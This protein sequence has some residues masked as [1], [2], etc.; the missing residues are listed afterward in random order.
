M[1]HSRSSIW[2]ARV[3]LLGVCAVS[4]V[5]AQ[6]F[7]PPFEAACVV[8]DN[9]TRFE[10]VLDYDGDGRMDAVS[11]LFPSTTTLRVRG[12]RNDGAGQLVPDWGI[13]YPGVNPITLAGPKA[14]LG[15]RRLQRRRPRRLRA[16]SELLPRLLDLGRS[17]RRAVGRLGDA[18]AGVHQRDPDGRLRRR[19]A[20]RRRAPRRTGFGRSDHSPRVQDAAGG[21]A[22][23]DLVDDVHGRRHS[24]QIFRVE[25]NGDG[26]P[27]VGVI[28]SGGL[29]PS[30]AIAEI[31][32]RPIAC[33]SSR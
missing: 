1:H 7:S 5:S 32:P 27:D 25:G 17:R 30:G 31:Y 11:V 12:Y 10:G 29:I 3:V 4:T 23:D 6:N 16:Q 22:G 20:D 15:D 26:L 21:P 14:V 19:R 13:T 28:R 18:R 8:A 24:V 9:Q 33:S 2:V